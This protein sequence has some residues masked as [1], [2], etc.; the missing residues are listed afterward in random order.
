MYTKRAEKY[1][2]RS[3]YTR[4]DPEQVGQ[5]F[6][7]ARN[8]LGASIPK[9][10]QPAS[11]EEL[12]AFSLKQ[13]QRKQDRATQEK[14]DINRALAASLEKTKNPGGISIR[15]KEGETAVG[16]SIKAKEMFFTF[17]GDDTKKSKGA[18]TDSE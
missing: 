9:A 13:G 7:N 6:K 8:R 12:R 2:A 11:L 4:R 17:Q 1:H 14:E 16:I 18:G 5:E 3:L 15:E 10:E